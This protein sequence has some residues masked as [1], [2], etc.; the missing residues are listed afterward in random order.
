MDAQPISLPSLAEDL[1]DRVAAAPRDSWVRVAFDGAPAA[2]PG[3]LADALT[4]PLRLRGREVLRVSADDFL[5]PASLRFEFGR[6][7]P[8]NFYTDWYDYGGLVRE[9][10]APLDPGGS[11]KVLPTLWDAVTDRATRAP[12]V[13]LPPGGVLLLDGPLLLGRGLPF[14][15]TVH[16]WL[17]P[18]ALAR[19]TP[20]KWRWT[21]PAYARYAEE[22]APARSADVVVRVDDPRHP[23]LVTRV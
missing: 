11:G 10:L 6:T 22:T 8:D 17:S 2:R 7:D 21:L 13:T 14:E 3:D 4:G 5:R 20:E 16:L 15:L 12:Y 1:A 19:R 23:A 18:G 9:V